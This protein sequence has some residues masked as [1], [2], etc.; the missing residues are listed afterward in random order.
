MA[1]LSSQ[2]L[3]VSWCWRG[4]GRLARFEK[5]DG[6]LAQVEVDEMLGL[7][8]HVAAKVPPYNA[9]PGGVVLLVK[10]LEG[11]ETGM[12]DQQ[13]SSVNFLQSSDPAP[14]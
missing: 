4:W 14:L 12:H 13:D 11:A 6:H 8:G 10:L 1:F 2:Y 5:Q 7:M 3:M 9:M